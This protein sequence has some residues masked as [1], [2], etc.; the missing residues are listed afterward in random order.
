LRDVRT[1]CIL[2]TS[3]H[4]KVTFFKGTK[5]V[6]KRRDWTIQAGKV[7]R[8]RRGVKGKQVLLFSPILGL[9]EGDIVPLKQELSIHSQ[10]SPRDRRKP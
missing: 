8:G 4:K 9:D 1:R 10:L 2:F 6:K 5:G 7:L 3:K